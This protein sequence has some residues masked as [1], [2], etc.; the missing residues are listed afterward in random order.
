MREPFKWSAVAGP[1]MSNY[2]VLNAAA[3]A[4]RVSQNNDGRSVAEQQGVSGSLLE[5]YRELIA[6]RKASVAL[7]R[8]GYAPVTASAASVVA[9]DHQDQQ[10]LVAINVSGSARTLT[11]DLGD[12]AIAGGA[13]VPTDL[14]TG[15]TLPALTDANRGAYPLTSAPTATGCCRSR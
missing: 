9:R 8:T 15:A 2:F 5:A 3:Y 1:P 7:R 11:L 10:V 4:G 14:L 6:A 12:F 13:T